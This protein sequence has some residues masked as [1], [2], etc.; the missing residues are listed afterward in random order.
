MNQ[1]LEWLTIAGIVL[2]TIAWL[3]GVVIGFRERWWW[4][5]L[6]LLIPPLFIFYYS[7]TRWRRSWAASLLMAVGLV[8]FLIPVIYTRVVPVDLGPLDT[9][10]EG[11]RHLTLTGWDQ[12]DYSILARCP[13]VVVLQMANGDVTNE[14]LGYLSKMKQLRRLDISHSQVDDTGLE[15]VT[16]MPALEELLL[17]NCKVTDAGFEKWLAPHEK[18][19]KLN[20]IGTE[21]TAD[22]VRDWR[23]ADRSRKAMR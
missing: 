18:L 21:V 20:L 3:W 14:T 1:L 19:N 13:D 6:L 16:N 22:S 11:E 23:K 9:I 4:G 5:L 15:I 12:T 2:V 8:V 7:P 17:Q 10:V